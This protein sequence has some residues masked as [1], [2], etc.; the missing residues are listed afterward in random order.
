TNKKLLVLYVLP[1]QKE[2]VL[3]RIHR[4]ATSKKVLEQRAMAEGEGEGEGSLNSLEWSHH[5]YQLMNN[6]SESCVNKCD[7][8]EEVMECMSTFKE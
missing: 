5:D 4:K 3:C 2:V 7:D 8:R 6:D 1:M